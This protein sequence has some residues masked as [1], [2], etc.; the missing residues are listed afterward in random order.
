MGHWWRDGSYIRRQ[1]R[2]CL[3][4]SGGNSVRV[5]RGF[6]RTGRSGRDSVMVKD[7]ER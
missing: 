5:L 6:D 2:A 4:E 1:E 7:T 3:V